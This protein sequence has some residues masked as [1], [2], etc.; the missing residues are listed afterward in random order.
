[1]TTTHLPARPYVGV[2]MEVTLEELPRLVG[3]AF[4]RVA[5]MLA[6]YGTAP[7]GA[8]IRYIAFRPG[9]VVD[10]EVGHLVDPAELE[11]APIEADVLPAGVY[12]VVHHE[13]P[14]AEL[15]EV[16][17][18]LMDSWPEAG[19]VPAMAHTTTGDDYASWYELY[20]D[21]PRPGPRGPE[22]AVEVCVLVLPA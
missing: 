10:I 4:D 21:M 17:A 14:Y 22:G 8:V 7:R 13:G 18:R 15:G 20:L 1:M 19:L 2:P 12:S 11:G 6:A 5:T 9:D 3:E 16:T